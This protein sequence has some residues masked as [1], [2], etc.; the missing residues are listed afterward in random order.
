M[1]IIYNEEPDMI[2]DQKDGCTPLC[3][4]LCNSFA[5]NFNFKGK[6]N[7]LE[8]RFSQFFQTYS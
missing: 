7:W 3:T 5:I 2:E 6:K 8:A 1:I 4:P